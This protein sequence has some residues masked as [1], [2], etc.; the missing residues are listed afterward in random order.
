MGQNRRVPGQ[1]LL[2]GHEKRAPTETGP[3]KSAYYVNQRDA[4][5]ATPLLHVHALGEL[6]GVLYTM[7]KHSYAHG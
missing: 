1:R 7:H 2:R 5:G 4:L 6:L 3:G